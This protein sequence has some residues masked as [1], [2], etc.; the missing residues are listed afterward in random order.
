MHMSIAT[1]TVRSRDPEGLIS[2]YVEVLGF[3]ALRREKGYAVLDCGGV[4]LQLSSGDTEPAREL[5]IEVSGIDNAVETLKSMHVLF[6]ELEIGMRPDGSI[7]VGS[8]GETF[9]GR[10]AVLHDPDGNRI[11]LEEHDEEWFPFMPR[12]FSANEQNRQTDG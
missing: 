8:I 10:Y 7:A 3:K 11:R 9:W 5:Q 6:D 4:S 2:F 1:M 12:W